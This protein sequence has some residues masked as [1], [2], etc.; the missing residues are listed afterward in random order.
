MYQL[1]NY[2]IIFK[3]CCQYKKIH[4]CDF[5]ALYRKVIA[6]GKIKAKRTKGL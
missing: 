6:Y 5:V 4:L 1:K 2:S 3:I